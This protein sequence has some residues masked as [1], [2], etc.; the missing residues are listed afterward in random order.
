[1]T[2]RGLALAALLLA[3]VSGAALAQDRPPPPSISVAAPPS[4]MDQAPKLPEGRLRLLGRTAGQVHFFALADL[5]RRDPIEIT[6]LSIADP[7]ETRAGSPA[8]MVVSREAIWCRQG[9]FADY[10]AWYSDT[11]RLLDAERGFTERSIVPDTLPALLATQ[12]CANVPDGQTVEGSNAA[13]SLGR[14]LLRGD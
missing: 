4:A 8:S 12:L 3:G 10:R 13:L 14:R 1:M 2:M 7:G 11:G 6:V 5:S 9:H